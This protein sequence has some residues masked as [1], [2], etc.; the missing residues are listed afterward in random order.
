MAT[1]KKSHQQPAPKP[2]V[3]SS[4]VLVERRDRADDLPALVGDARTILREVRAAGGRPWSR[5]VDKARWEHATLLGVI[6]EWGDPRKW[7]L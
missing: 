2:R 1:K 7:A 4:A 5:L 3:K 6:L